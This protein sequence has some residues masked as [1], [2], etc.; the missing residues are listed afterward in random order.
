MN[1][2]LYDLNLPII[3]EIDFFSDGSILELQWRHTEDEVKNKYT[4][5]HGLVS[6]KWLKNRKN[7]NFVKESLIFS[8]SATS[9]FLT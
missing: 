4:F 8:F 9:S 2:Y 7:N 1:S 5:T 3:K 6:A